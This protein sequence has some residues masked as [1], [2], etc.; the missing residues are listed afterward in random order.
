MINSQSLVRISLKGIQVVLPAFYDTVCLKHGQKREKLA[1]AVRFNPLAVSI[2]IVY[3]YNMREKLINSDAVKLLSG[4]DKLA[5]AVSGGRD[6]M[7]LL[8]WFVRSGEY[9]G[10]FFVLH[11]N[12]N[13]RG[14]NSDADCELVKEYC[15]EHGVKIEIRNE[16]VKGFCQKGGYGIEQGARLIRRAIFKEITEG[17]AACRVVTAHH[18]QDFAESVLMHVFRGSGIDG[19]CGIKDDDGVMLRP[20]LRTERAQIEKY[21]SENRVPYRDDESNF[22]QSY[23]RNYIRN[24]VMPLIRKVYPNVDNSLAF[25]AKQAG[26]AKSYIDANSVSP[27]L[28]NGE[29]VLDISV[30][31]APSALASS[32]IFKALELIGARVDCE[33]VHIDS[34]KALKDKKNGTRVCLPHN[35]EVEK[36][37]NKLYFYRKREKDERVLPYTGESFSIGGYEVCIGRE[38]KLRFDPSKIPSDAVIRTRREGDRFRKFR[39]G[40]KSL[41]DYLTDKNCP[42]HLRDNLPLIACGSEVLLIAGVEISDR[43]AVDADSAEEKHIDT[44]RLL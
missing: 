22:D 41:G 6:S 7:A 17:N 30:L 42:L 36:H 34:I 13:L 39:G 35:V 9:K 5:L 12:H 21:V 37:K 18:L 32:S 3:N 2:K 14:E 40:E 19:L 4:Y 16:D 24:T 1:A 8:D 31:D 25:L 28:E 11:V 26:Y 33:G 10:E 29:A 20:L 43:I 27:V 15:K 23:R 38:G 44:K